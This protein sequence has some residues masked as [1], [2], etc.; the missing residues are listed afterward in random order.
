MENLLFS[1][2]EIS[3]DETKDRT[4]GGAD[5]LVELGLGHGGEAEDAVRVGVRRVREECAV[6]DSVV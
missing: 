6:K 3:T 4:E 1:L 2:E 5:G